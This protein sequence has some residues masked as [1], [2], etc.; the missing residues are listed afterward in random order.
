VSHHARR[1]LWTASAV[2]FAEEQVDGVLET[3]E[4]EL[5]GFLEA[6]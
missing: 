3:L 1:D 5:A 6:M 2:Q 4:S